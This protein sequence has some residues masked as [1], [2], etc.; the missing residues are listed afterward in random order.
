VR[1]YFERH[2]DQ[3]ALREPYVRIRHLA[4]TNADSAAAVRRRLVDARRVPVD[5]LW[6]NLIRKHAAVPRRAERISERF[7]PEGRLFTQLPYVQDELAT[8]REGEVAPVIEDNDLFHVLQLVRR[9]PA[10]TDPELSWLKPEIQRRLKIRTRKQ[11]YARE[12]QRLRNRA[13]ADN[14]IETP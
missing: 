5:S 1:T 10:G 13:R 6:R 2:R 11:M 14:L 4:T 12:V 9:L 3:L 8:L 7:M